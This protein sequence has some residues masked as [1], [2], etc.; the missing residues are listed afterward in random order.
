LSRL[1]WANE[2]QA[3]DLPLTDGLPALLASARALIAKA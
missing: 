2:L 1:I 3:R